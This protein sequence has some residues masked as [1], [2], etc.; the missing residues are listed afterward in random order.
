M[1]SKCYLIE[2]FVCNQKDAVGDVAKKL[3][4]FEQRHIYV[5]DDDQ[6][7]V[8]LIS[9]S[10]ILDKVVIAGKDP[11]GVKAE[12]IMSRDIL[13]FDDEDDAKKAY[14]AMSEKGFVSSAVTQNG[15]MVGVLTLKETI[16]FVTDPK[17][18]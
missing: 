16:K 2:P 8:G 11:T 5:V 12:D 14:K 6:K 4:E 1:I 15:K 10:D 9:V 13:V 17:N 18:I 7:P 3:R